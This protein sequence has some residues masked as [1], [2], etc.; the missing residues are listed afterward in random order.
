M[1]CGGGNIVEACYRLWATSNPYITLCIHDASW[2]ELWSSDVN[3]PNSEI[4]SSCR[5]L[6]CRK[7]LKWQWCHFSW[8][9]A[10]LPFSCE[11]LRNPWLATCSFRLHENLPSFDWDLEPGFIN[12]WIYTKTLVHMKVPYQKI[13]Q[14][15]LLN[16]LDDTKVDLLAKLHY[17]EGVQLKTGNK[18]VQHL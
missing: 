4:S 13:V 2:T 9:N 17:H 12:A 1:F 8:S 15:S 14:Q 7:A 16:I 5:A 11:Q 3:G 10:E 18:H 6:R